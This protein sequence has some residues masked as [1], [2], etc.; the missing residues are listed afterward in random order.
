MSRVL[1]RAARCSGFSNCHIDHQI[2]GLGL[3]PPYLCAG[4][5]LEQ[6]RQI[7]A[8]FLLFLRLICKLQLHRGHT[9]NSAARRVG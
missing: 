9:S 2:G 1:L 5:A 7:G 6:H 8:G 4:V 3:V